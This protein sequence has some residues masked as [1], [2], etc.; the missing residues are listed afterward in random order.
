MYDKNNIF[1][2]II[3]GESPAEKIYEDDLVM[4]IKDIAPACP[5]HIL[6]IPKGEYISFDDFTINASEFEIVHFYKIV[7]KI[8]ANLKVTQDGYSILSNI[9]VNGG[10]VVPH[11]HLHILAGKKLGSLTRDKSNAPVDG[12]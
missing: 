3:R 1:A 6:V 5:I 2:K 10:Q 9:G 8:C 4:A 12:E 11:M 7:Q